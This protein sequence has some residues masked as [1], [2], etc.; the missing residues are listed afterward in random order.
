[1]TTQSYWNCTGKFQREYDI[2]SELIPFEGR[3]MGF[4]ELE[5]LRRAANV[6][7]D[8]FNNGLYNLGRSF[9][10][11]FGFSHTMYR[12]N[13]WTSY[14]WVK[15]IDFNRIAPK[16]DAVMDQIIEDAWKAYQARQA[17]EAA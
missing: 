15:E 14:G 17:K 11:I 7:Y 1:M 4:K 8:T 5:K 10:S 3:V 16:M 12:Y 9:R 13:S 2:L 6:Y